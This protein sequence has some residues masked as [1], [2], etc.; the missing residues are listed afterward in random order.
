MCQPE[1]LLLEPL[2]FPRD[3]D[4]YKDMLELPIAHGSNYQAY[5]L[6]YSGQ[7]FIS[8][9]YDTLRRSYDRMHELLEDAHLHN[10][11]EMRGG[12]LQKQFMSRCQTLDR[13]ILALD[14]EIKW[15]YDIRHENTT[16]HGGRS[17][18]VCGSIRCAPWAQRASLSG[19]WMQIS[20][21]MVS[22]T[23]GKSWSGSSWLGCSLNSSSIPLQRGYRT[24]SAREKTLTGTR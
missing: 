17:R 22:L 19:F 1:Q 16:P 8:M 21:P 13:L 7:F 5:G 12:D 24:E 11:S 20:V 2:K 15:K 14:D 6:H 10:G 3:E 9:D 18:D 23:G 4:K